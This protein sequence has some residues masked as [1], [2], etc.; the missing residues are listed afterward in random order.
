MSA[1][2]KIEVENDFQAL[3]A[4]VLEMEADEIKPQSAF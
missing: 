2:S 1:G 4:E 3:G